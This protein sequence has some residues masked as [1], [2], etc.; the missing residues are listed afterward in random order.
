M[1]MLRYD[2][3]FVSDRPEFKNC[4]LFFDFRAKGGGT[5]LGNPTFRRWQS[6]GFTLTEASVGC[7][8]PEHWY[9]F[10]RCAKMGTL[11]RVTLDRVLAADDFTT[12]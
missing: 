9:T 7:V 6:W 1:D 3:A 10:R 12:I 4:V 8:A 11:R 2:R 5:Y